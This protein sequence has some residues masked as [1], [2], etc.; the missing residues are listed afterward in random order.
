[1]KIKILEKTPLL[2][3]KRGKNKMGDYWTCPYCG[4]NLDNDEKCNCQQGG[5]DNKEGGATQ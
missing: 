1:M 2:L 5:V 4:A 3:Q